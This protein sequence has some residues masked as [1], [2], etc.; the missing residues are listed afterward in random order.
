MREDAP[1]NPTC[2]LYHQTDHESAHLIPRYAP[3]LG[4]LGASLGRE[5]EE[6]TEPQEASPRHP[7]MQWP[8][9]RPAFAL[10]EGES[11]GSP[12]QCSLLS[13]WCESPCWAGGPEGWGSKEVSHL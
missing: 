12:G 7:G 11:L 13:A 10:P 4:T 8:P 9:R 3:G 5:R 2:Y 1:H 6:G